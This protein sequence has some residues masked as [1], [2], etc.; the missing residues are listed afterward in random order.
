V[1]IPVSAPAG[2]GKQSGN[3]NVLVVFLAVFS[4]FL[5]LVIYVWLKDP[6][7][8]T[9]LSQLPTAV[10]SA[11]EAKEAISFTQTKTNPEGEALLEEVLDK[12]L[13]VEDAAADGPKKPA[14]QQIASAIDSARPAATLVTEE[15]AA[16]PIAGGTEYVYTVKNGETLF[17]IASKFK[18]QAALLREANGLKDDNVQ[19]GQAIKI[20]IAALHKV[21][22]GQFL[23]TL[24]R[25]YNVS[26]SDIRKANNLATDQIN[27]DQELIIPLP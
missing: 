26:Q 15:P 24:S 5:L 19:N 4:I 14:E 22:S 21:G 10:E 11:D 6:M 1:K 13:K 3:P 18:N 12:P 2:R 20:K 9:L 16:A 25:K 8:G 17:S 7:Q 27:L 23:G